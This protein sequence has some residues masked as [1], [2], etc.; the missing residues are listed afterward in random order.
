[1]RWNKMKIAGWGNVLSVEANIAR[2]ERH[3]ALAELITGND[4][5][6]PIGSLRSYG[7]AALAPKGHGIK[8][9]RMDRLVSFD[10]ETGKLEVEA[11]IRLGEILRLFAPRGWMPV[12]VPGTGMTTVGGAIANDIHGKNHH[13]DGSFGQHVV[14]LVLLTADGQA[15]RISSTKETQLFK[16]T[17]G[18]VGQTGLITSAVLQLVRCPSTK[19]RV[20][21]NRMPNLDRFIEGFETSE[22][23]YQVGWIDALA[24]GSD[25]GRGILEE[26]EF[27]DTP[28][29]PFRPARTKS[30]PLTPPG[31]AVSRPVVKIFNAAYLRRVPVDGRTVVRDMTE[32]FFPLDKISGWNRLYGK[33][34]FFQFQSVLPLEGARDGLADLLEIVSDGGIASP[35]A[36]LKKMGAGRAGY[37]SFPMEGYT[38]AVDLPNRAATPAILSDLAEITQRHKGR[39]YLAKDGAIDAPAI[40]QMYPEIDKFREQVAKIDGVGKFSSIMAERL[41]LRG[42]A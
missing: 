31:V 37:M 16:A 30:V 10:E 4:H 7:D 18:G 12:V 20:T 40:E 22:A 33:K 28:P 8:T 32:F 2:P 26:A 36:V 17:V 3:S 38:L 19:M 42:T 6:L 14:S 39:V 11:G 35:L 34:G 24:S 5:I 29:E 25:I 9:A 15:R 21:E 1:M 27:A 23:P 13:R 41:N